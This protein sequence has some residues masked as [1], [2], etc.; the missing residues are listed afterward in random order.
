MYSALSPGVLRNR[1][2]FRVFVFLFSPTCAWASL[3][4]GETKRASHTVTPLLP[5]RGT[6]RHTSQQPGNRGGAWTVLFQHVPRCTEHRSAPSGPR[7]C[8][9][10]VRDSGLGEASPGCCL[11]HMRDT[12]ADKATG[13]ALLGAE[14][15]DSSSV[16][17]S[18]H[19][20]PL[21]HLRFQAWLLGLCAAL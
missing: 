9:L 13:A 1:V 5:W 4:V 15:I 11:W 8:C 14:R 18:L 16:A 17:C 12:G 6:P 2:T 19:A 20:K 10:G 21:G 7:S 3:T